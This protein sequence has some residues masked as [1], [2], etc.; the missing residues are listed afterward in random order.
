MLYPCNCWQSFTVNTL[1][2]ELV[3][4]NE[5]ICVHRFYDKQWTSSGG[6]NKKF[7]GSFLWQQHLHVRAARPT[8]TRTSSAQVDQNSGG[9][10][11]L[12]A[13]VDSASRQ[14]HS[15]AFSHVRRV[16]API[17]RLNCR[18]CQQA[19]TPALQQGE[20]GGGQR[21]GRPFRPFLF[22][23]PK[24]WQFEAVYPCFGAIL[25]LYRRTAAL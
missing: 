21:R 23:F 11:D 3:N 8:Y 20:H 16:G 19:A 15:H 10:V 13:V 24:T 2:S 9:L 12:T 1:Q 17:H 6:L 14:H 22:F 18:E 4:M 25:R 7:R 5:W